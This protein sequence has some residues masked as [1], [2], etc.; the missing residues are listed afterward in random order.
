[1]SKQEKI[2][3]EARIP[4]S[5]MREWSAGRIKTLFDGLALVVEAIDGQATV[6][7]ETCQKVIPVDPPDSGVESERSGG[8]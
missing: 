8:G 5:E 1:M 2:H 7:V 3:I 6:I 4:A